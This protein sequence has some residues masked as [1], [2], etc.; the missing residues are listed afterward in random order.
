MTAHTSRLDQQ[1]P[2]MQSVNWT[3]LLLES[4]LAQ[5]YFRT[6][7]QPHLGEEKHTIN[8]GHS[9]LYAT[10]KGSARTSLG[11]NPQLPNYFDL[12]M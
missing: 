9:I 1:L 5:S 6:I 4:N 7:G 3:I 2:H 10:P 8:R 11:P 12:E